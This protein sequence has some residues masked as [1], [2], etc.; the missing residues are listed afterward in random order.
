MEE[1]GPSIPMQIQDRSTE[2]VLLIDY[3]RRLNGEI[4][5]RR[6]DTDRPANHGEETF[7]KHFKSASPNEDD[8]VILDLEI[9]LCI[10]FC[11][12]V[13]YCNN[14]PLTPPRISEDSYIRRVGG[15]RKALGH[16]NRLNDGRLSCKAVHSSFLHRTVNIEASAVRDMNNITAKNRN[17]KRPITL[18]EEFLDIND[19]CFGI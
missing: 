18:I 11:L 6:T 17:I 15:K 8:I 14:L 4:A 5:S 13:V 3:N 1:S 16:G 12:F 19:N 10:I 7:N 2:R 9:V